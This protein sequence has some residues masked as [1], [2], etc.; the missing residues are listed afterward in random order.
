MISL[1]W[2]SDRLNGLKKLK[3]VSVVVY[4]YQPGHENTIPNTLSH[5]HTY[6]SGFANNH[7]SVIAY[8]VHN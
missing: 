3:E 8:L 5:I 1:T 7:T 6:N 4:K 2:I